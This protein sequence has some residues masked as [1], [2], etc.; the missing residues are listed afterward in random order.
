MFTGCNFKIKAIIN[1]VN[2]LY[3]SDYQTIIFDKKTTAFHGSWLFRVSVNYK[4]K[5]QKGNEPISKIML[6][7]ENHNSTAKL[8]EVDSRK[9][10]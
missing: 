6:I 9:G 7:T 5:L 4:A 2:L 8:P 10:T 1:F 3:N